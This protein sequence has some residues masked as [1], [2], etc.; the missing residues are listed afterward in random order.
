MQK[1]GQNGE[2]CH[3]DR[4]ANPRSCRENGLKMPVVVV[5]VDVVVFLMS[6]T[7]DV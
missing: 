3:G 5:V 6:R 4:K 1:I 2:D 7:Q